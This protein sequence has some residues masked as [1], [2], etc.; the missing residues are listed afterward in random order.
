MAGTCHLVL[1]CRQQ[2]ECSQAH[3]KSHARSVAESLSVWWPANALASLR[4]V[5]HEGVQ[6]I[7]SSTISS[8]RNTTQRLRSGCFTHGPACIC[9]RKS[10]H[11]RYFLGF[12]FVFTVF[13][14]QKMHLLPR[15]ESLQVTVSYCWHVCMF[16]CFGHSHFQPSGLKQ[17]YSS[18][19]MHTSAS[20][21]SIGKRLL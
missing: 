13:A 9:I 8:S 18:A 15:R 7:C 11:S 3:R 1:Y 20:E 14:N 21:T 5:V 19:N 12:A 6:Q 16:G 10:H 4:C 2:D 17:N